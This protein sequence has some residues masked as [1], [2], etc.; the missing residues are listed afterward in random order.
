LGN[1]SNDQF[2]IQ[3]NSVTPGFFKTLGV[4][5]LDGRDFSP[6]DRVSG[7][8]VCIINYA[9]QRLVFRDENPI[10]RLLRL[11]DGSSIQV[12]GVSRDIKYTENQIAVPFAYRPLAQSPLFFRG[13]LMVRGTG[14]I[15]ETSSL[16]HA[17][18]IEVNPSI[19][20]KFRPMDDEIRRVLLPSR[21]GMYIAGVPGVLALILGL[22]GTYGTM[23]LIVAQRRAEIG[24]RIAL[25]ASPAEAVRLMLRQGLQWT[26]IGLLFGIAGGAIMTFALSRFFYGISPFDLTAFVFTLTAVTLTA[27]TACYIPAKLASRLDVMQVLRQ[28]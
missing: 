21:I 17:K 22:I 14:D 11:S 4:P 13:V 15:A 8:A 25:G 2:E 12:I 27:T 1:R 6:S 24:V 9:T 19:L 23:S 10:G 26:A 20:T 3:T 28:E 16:V 7:S 5:L 18:I